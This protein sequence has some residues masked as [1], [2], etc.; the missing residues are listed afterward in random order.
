[1]EYKDAPM[2]DYFFGGVLIIGL[3]VLFFVGA[4]GFILTDCSGNKDNR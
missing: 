2:I 4:I 3:T 1:M